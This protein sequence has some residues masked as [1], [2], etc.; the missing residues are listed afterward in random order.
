M[1]VELS[2]LAE[3]MFYANKEQYL[4]SKSGRIIDDS[5][6]PSEASEHG[7]LRI[8]KYSVAYVRQQYMDYMHAHGIIDSAQMI[9]FTKYPRFNL[10]K[11]RNSSTVEAEYISRVHNLCEA[12]G[13]ESDSY[14]LPDQVCSHPTYDDFESAKILELAKIWCQENGIDT[15]NYFDIPC[16][17]EEQKRREEDERRTWMIWYNRPSSMALYNR[18]DFERIIDK[19][20]EIMHNEWLEKKKIYDASIS[21]K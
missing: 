9:E 8:P 6:Q 11:N 20:I 2:L 3:T 7:Y 21:N 14:G 17:E 18:E 10:E 12:I 15:Y 13:M 1:R 4:D 16:S 19:K 5:L